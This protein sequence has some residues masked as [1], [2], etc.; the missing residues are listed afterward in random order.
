M[1]SFSQKSP[2]RLVSFTASGGGIRKVRSRGF[3][4]S[5]SGQD[6]RLISSS[7]GGMKQTP[8]MKKLAGSTENLARLAVA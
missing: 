6:V 2:G 7:A 5:S 8:S 4:H 3:V 1:I